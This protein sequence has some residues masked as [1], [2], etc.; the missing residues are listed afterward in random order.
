MKYKLKFNRS[1]KLQFNNITHPDPE[2]G[3]SDSK[4]GRRD[5][6]MGSMSDS[7]M[8]MS[9]SGISKSDLFS[10]KYITNWLILRQSY[11]YMYI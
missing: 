8:G 2:M 6:E 10:V 4:L 9:D 3:G 7:E 11:M 5:S 1:S